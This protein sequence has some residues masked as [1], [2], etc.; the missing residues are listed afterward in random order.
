VAD[1]TVLAEKGAMID[2]AFHMIVADISGDNLGKDI[3]A[4]INDGHRSLKIFTT[5]DKVR[6]GDEDILDTLC[7]ARDHGAMVCFHA[8]NDG[9]IRWATKRLLAA[10]KTAPKHHAQ[11]H[12]RAAEIEALERMCRFSKIT[13]QPIMLFHISTAEGTQVVRAA[14]G[15]GARVFAET[16]PHYL[17]MTEDILDQPRAQGAAFLCSPPQRTKDDQLALWL[18]LERGDLQLVSS[19]HAPYRMDESGKFANGTDAPFNKMANGMP[20]LELRLPLMFNEM[21]SKGRFGV[22]KF[23]ELTST[24]PADLFGLTG[25][26]RIAPGADADIAIWNPD[27]HARFGA[28][29]LHD[30]VGYNPFEGRGVTGWPVTVLSRG[31]VVVEGGNVPAKP[32]RGKRVKMSVS[33][34]MRPV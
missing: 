10:S 28:N 34:A 19:D 16:C 18:A 21:V 3:P 24:A 25:K 31:E 17:F 27:M 6:L 11:S 22:Q 9:L 20:G 13:G 5:Y 14:R 7:T 15:R 30:N 29:D 4:L 8:E 26:G 33:K 32:G 2:Y 12:P 1:Y 23:V